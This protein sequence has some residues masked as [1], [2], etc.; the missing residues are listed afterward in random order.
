M[1]YEDSQYLRQH[2]RLTVHAVVLPRE[3]KRGVMQLVFN[4]SH[5]LQGR[6]GSFSG[7]EE[8]FGDAGVEVVEGPLHIGGEPGR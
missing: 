1:P 7:I 8:V 3:A 6:L 2:L 4:R 5:S